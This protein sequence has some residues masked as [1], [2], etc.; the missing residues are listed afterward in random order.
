VSTKLQLKINNNNNIL[1]KL[2]LSRTYFL[3][4]QISNF[5]KNRPVGAVLFHQDRRTEGQTDRQT[6]IYD[7]ANSRFLQ[8]YEHT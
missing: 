2:E 6:D 8:L 1:M 5:K 7:E 4:T 3:N